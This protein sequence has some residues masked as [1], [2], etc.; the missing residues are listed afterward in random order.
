MTIK[1]AGHELK[2]P[3]C[4]NSLFYSRS[5]LLNTAGM[6]ILNLDWLNQSAENYI[7]SKCGRIEWFTGKA[8][9]ILPLSAS[10]TAEPADCLSCGAVIPSGQ[11]SCP[12]CGW[13]YT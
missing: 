2:C 1:I 11:T 7:C 4:A 8:D 5:W 10:S 3:H 13:T 12:D 9:Q 6:T